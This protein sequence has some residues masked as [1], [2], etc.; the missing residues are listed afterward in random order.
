MEE[1]VFE[2]AA[3]GAAKFLASLFARIISF[4]TTMWLL[5]F[6]SYIVARYLICGNN[7][8]EFSKFADHMR[9]G[10]KDAAIAFRNVMPGIAESAKFWSEEKLE[11]INT[12]RRKR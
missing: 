11:K 6:L 12:L 9:S 1:T 10:C 2:M 7:S 5:Y 4:G 3:M 8:E